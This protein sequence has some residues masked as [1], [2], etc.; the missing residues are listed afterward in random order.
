MTSR[1]LGACASASSTSFCSSSTSSLADFAS[2]DSLYQLNTVFGKSRERGGT[3]GLGCEK[4]E[5]R[6]DA[7][8]RRRGLDRE[9][10]G[11]LRAQRGRVSRLLVGL[12]A[13]W[14][15]PV[16]ANHPAPREDQPWACPSRS[17]RR[18][19]PRPSPATRGRP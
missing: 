17:G 14:I 1:S 18:A 8:S 4:V 2:A 15:R 7:A 11:T 6:Q 13:R 5:V 16:R 10:D 9:R 19:P 3:H 12:E